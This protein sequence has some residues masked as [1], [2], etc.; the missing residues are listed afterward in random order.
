MDD[1]QLLIGVPPGYTISVCTRSYLDH[2]SWYTSILRTYYGES[3]HTLYEWLSTVIDKLRYDTTW[4]HQQNGQIVA[5]LY[6]L[7]DTYAR[8]EVYGI[9]LSHL[10]IMVPLLT[11]VVP[12]S[13][14]PSPLEDV[15]EISYV[16]DLPWWDP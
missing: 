6:R 11:I 12:D 8:D 13:P 5:A 2:Q 14:P 1:Y 4:D 15:P 3:R 16:R 10:A 9:Q 7:R